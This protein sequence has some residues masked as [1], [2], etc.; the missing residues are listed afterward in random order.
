MEIL[1]ELTV[2]YGNG[3]GWR[4]RDLGAFV[5]LRIRSFFLVCIEIENHSRN[6]ARKKKSVSRFLFWGDLV[7]R[8]RTSTWPIDR[9]GPSVSHA[10][11]KKI[12]SNCLSRRYAFDFVFACQQR[13]N[14]KLCNWNSWLARCSK[15]HVNPIFF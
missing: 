4:V 3:S 7:M 12:I 8:S 10:K 15:L 1:S 14:R 5:S 6:C 9:R 2:D 11:G 13:R